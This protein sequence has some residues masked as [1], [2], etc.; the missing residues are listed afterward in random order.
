MVWVDDLLL[1]TT[2]DEIM[3][4]LKAELKLIFNLTN[5]G[6]PNK[7]VG[8]EITHWERLHNDLSKELY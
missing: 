3:T 4:N 8:I 2:S 7:I 5:I 6:E 1:F